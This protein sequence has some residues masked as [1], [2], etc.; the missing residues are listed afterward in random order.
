MLTKFEDR[1]L[2]TGG[3]QETAV[4]KI[5]P[6]GKAFRIL[7]DQIYADKITAVIR[8]LATNAYDAHIAAGCADKPFDLGIP[9]MFYPEFRIRDY[10]CSMTH[11]EIM[12][13]Y[14]TI[15]DSSKD[16]DNIAVG[17][18]GLGSKTPFAYTDTFTVTAFLN[19]V[20]RVYTAY[21][22][23]DGVPEIALM[24]KET[25]TEPNGLE[26]SFPVES[27][28]M[29]DF[30]VKA[31]R[32]MEGFDVRPNDVN[33]SGA[34]K[35]EPTE[36]VLQGKRWKLLPV[37]NWATR[38]YVRQGCVLYPV[39]A[40]K[41]LNL[42]THVAAVLGS[43]IILDVPIGEVEITAARDGLHYDE[44]TIQNLTARL[45]QI[46]DEALALLREKVAGATTY[47]EAVKIYNELYD[48][49]GGRYN[50][51]MDRA[52]QRLTYKGRK[53]RRTISVDY[54]KPFARAV[55][56]KLC[57][58]TD[59]EVR[60]G[61]SHRARAWSGK[62]ENVTRDFA[63]EGVV[64]YIQNPLYKTTYPGQRIRHD[65]IQNRA[66]NKMM[67][68]IKCNPY[69]KAFKKVLAALGRPDPSQFIDVEKLSLPQTAKKGGGSSKVMCKEVDGYYEVDTEVDTTAKNIVYIEKLRNDFFDFDR[70]HS[71][72]DLTGLWKA[73]KKYGIVGMNDRLVIIPGTHRNKIKKAGSNWRK[74]KPLVI[75]YLEKAMSEKNAS[76]TYELGGMKS[77][78]DAMNNRD[79]SA[80]HNLALKLAANGDLPQK[81]TPFREYIARL[82]V[83]LRREAR[84]SPDNTLIQ[85]YRWIHGMEPGSVV[86]EA[87]LF[88]QPELYVEALKAA[89]AYPLIGQCVSPWSN[90]ID[91]ELRKNL[92][93]YVDCVDKAE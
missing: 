53:L 57:I 46:A 61:R 38:F 22:R 76:A 50:S 69:S 65:Y 30:Y 4:F 72:L 51:M 26:V 82:R 1:T 39:D 32:V 34:W 77:A 43:N 37:E 17:K 86:P 15:F 44:T 55:H 16:Q 89:E 18:F 83:L 27:D 67:V 85:H 62:W 25:T 21:L 64:Y 24:L 40:S 29:G 92:L 84:M 12:G 31:G 58:L 36:P 78:I 45:T 60:T 33:G 80:L 6:N 2:V 13:L 79:K 59:H 8:E 41:M 73:M 91:K 23:P 63:P 66:A 71:T 74:F 56:G 10:G 19:G 9:T 93:H 42:P 87:D 5:A 3:T 35:S 47:Q 14:A 75:A 90:H 81:R 20:K 28:D 49:M 11:G 7:I 88:V 70:N 48:G 68:W 54:T 52:L